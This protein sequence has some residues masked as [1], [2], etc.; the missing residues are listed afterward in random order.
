MSANVTERELGAKKVRTVWR[1]PGTYAKHNSKVML[2]VAQ[3]GAW[4]N[5]HSRWHYKHESIREGDLLWWIH[6]YTVAEIQPDP[7]PPKP[8]DLSWFQRGI[9]WVLGLIRRPASPIPT[10][11]VHGDSK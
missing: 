1:K 2:I 9:Q 8:G 10:A 5:Q 3:P 6:G 11:R 7:P 4:L